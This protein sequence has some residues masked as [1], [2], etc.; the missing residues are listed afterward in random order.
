MVVILEKKQHAEA[1]VVRQKQKADER[2]KYL[3]TI[4]LISKQKRHASITATFCKISVKYTY[5]VSSQKLQ[6]C[7]VV[8]LCFG[9]EFLTLITEPIHTNKEEDMDIKPKIVLLGILELL[10]EA[11]DRC[12]EVCA[13]HAKT[14][15]LALLPL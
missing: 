10:N 1:R 9:A 7:Y 3:R 4:Y 14:F 12:G 5:N 2:Q 15:Y 13:E 6:E 8:K 11:F